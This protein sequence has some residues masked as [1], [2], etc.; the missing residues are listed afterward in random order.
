MKEEPGGGAEEIGTVAGC[1]GWRFVDPE[2]EAN[3]SAER[4]TTLPVLSSVEMWSWLRRDDLVRGWPSER[5]YGEG[6]WV[7]CGE[8]DVSY[9]DG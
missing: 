1:C 2:R 9:A 4:G 6:L 7:L 5:D 8:G 3:R